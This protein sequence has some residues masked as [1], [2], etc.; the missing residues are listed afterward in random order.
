MTAPG[1]TPSADGGADTEQTTS[2]AAAGPTVAGEVP[3]NVPRDKPD[4][5][6][7][8][9]ASGSAARYSPPGCSRAAQH[10]STARSDGEP[11]ARDAARGTGAGPQAARSGRAYVVQVSSQ[12][13]QDQAQA[14][15]DNLRQRYSGVLVV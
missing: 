1:A 4:D 2:P 8:L 15:F 6:Q 11:A 10:R 7:T 14:A 12:R 13:T 5:I 9:A 3:A